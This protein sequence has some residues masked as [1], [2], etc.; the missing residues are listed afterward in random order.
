MKG[1]DETK[2]SLA[3]LAGTMCALLGS[4]TMLKGIF[5]RKNDSKQR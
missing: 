1:D 4:I 3:I 5:E 2:V